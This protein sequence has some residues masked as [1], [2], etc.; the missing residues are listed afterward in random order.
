M[1]NAYWYTV[2]GRLQDATVAL[3]KAGEFEQVD[4]GIMGSSLDMGSLPAVMLIYKADGRERD[5]QALLGR[6]HE[7]LRKQLGARVPNATEN[8]LLAEVAIVDGQRASAVRYLKT[9]MKLAPLP[10][11]FYPELPWLKSLEG[12]TGLRGTRCRTARSGA[13]RSEPRSRRWMRHR[14]SRTAAEFG[15]LTRPAADLSRKRER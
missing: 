15:A 13:L 10:E 14:N 9:A 11:R 8:M 7:R 1:V 4:S 5:A 12:R 3:A 6:F 2:Q